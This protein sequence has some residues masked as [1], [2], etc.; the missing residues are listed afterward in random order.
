MSLGNPSSGY[1]FTL[2]A[3]KRQQHPNSTDNGGSVSPLMWDV[4]VY[5]MVTTLQG[6]HK[7]FG[8]GGSGRSICC[9]S[10]KFLVTIAAHPTQP[11]QQ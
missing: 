5:Y 3:R 6:Q 11:T 4:A 2:A 8:D 1:L 9:T 7:V 10:M